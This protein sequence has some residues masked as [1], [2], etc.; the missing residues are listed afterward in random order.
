[1]DVSLIV[2]SGL[3]LIREWS[4]PLLAAFAAVGVISM[5]LI[6][7]AKDLVPIRRRFHDKELTRWLTAQGG[8]GDRTQLIQL[9]A[10]GDATALCELPT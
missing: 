10:G 3:N 5:A 9:A 6:Q 8:L 2:E 1:M 7:A 4:L